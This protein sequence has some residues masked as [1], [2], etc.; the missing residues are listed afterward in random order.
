MF[1]ISYLFLAMVKAIRRTLIPFALAFMVIL[2][3]CTAQPRDDDGSRAPQRV[4]AT[5]TRANLDDDITASRH[6]A[7]TRAVQAVSPAVV[8]INVTE[9][10]EYSRDPFL[11]EFYNDPF[12]QRFFPRQRQ[13]FRQEVHGLGSGFIIS[14]D[15]YIV[16]NDHVAGTASKVVVTMTDGKQY[17][18]RI[19]G[20]DPTTDVALLKIEG[21]KNLP[22]LELGN[23][24]DVLVGEWAIALGNPFGLF[25]I[26]SK[27][28]V[29]VGVISN[30]GVDLQP[31]QDRIYRG[32]LQTDAA[33]S[34]GN[35]GGPLVNALGQ[36]IGV[37]ATIY[38]TSQSRMGAGSIGIGFAIPI[39]RARVVI[40]ELRKNGKIERDF[41]T[42]MRFQQIDANIARYLRLK[43]TEGVV[44]VELAP[45]SPAARAGLEIGDVIV[46][47]N[48][49]PVKTEDDAIITLYDSRVGDTI[50]LRVQRDGRQ[51][52]TKMVLT[53]RGG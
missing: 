14:S 28:T 21:G 52:E 51:M 53:K 7:I 29:T 9:V 43:S 20:S 13:T 33:I 4:P 50:T 38:S 5:P 17:D 39:N 22:Y 41:W 31:Q 34:S 18:A 3:A 19:V 26:N 44:I 37:N 35:S 45:N 10:R 11:D 6:N 2:A 46:A 25:D 8:G 42:G 16:T 15:G 24:D 36:V 49:Q 23:S 27:P 40:D 30:T 12:F 32:M 1:P 48:G 47:I